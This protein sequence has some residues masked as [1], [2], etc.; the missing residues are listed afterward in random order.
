M[1]TLGGS[2]LPS[3]A[4]RIAIATARVYMRVNV[5]KQVQ[6]TR[7][8][9]LSAILRVGEILRQFPYTLYQVFNC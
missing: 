3:F 4:E 6:G 2:S 5:A 7:S 1:V 9:I 8:A